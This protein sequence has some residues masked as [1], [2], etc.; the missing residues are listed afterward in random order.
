[1]KLLLFLLIMII[2]S[3][4]LVSAAQN[5]KDELRG[6]KREIKA[7]KQLITR[8]RKV[9][10][11]ISTEL[12]E[13]NRNLDQKVS[14]LGRLDH[15]LRGVESSLDRT[16][17][18]IGRVSEDAS[19]KRQ[20]IERRLTSLYKAGELGALRM[21]F[22]AESFPQIVENI[23][24]MRSI[25]DNDKR[26]FVEYNQKIE[27]LK[28]LKA[29][30]ER[31]A[32]KKER[33]LENMAQKKREIEQEKRKKADYLIKVRQD[34]KS[35]E[36]SL[37][38]LQTN[39]SRLQAMMVRLNALS[40][41]KL[42]SRH[43][44]PGSKPKPLADLP[45]VPDRGFASQKGRMTLPVRGAILESFGKHKHPEF[46]SYTFSKGLSISSSAGTEIKSIYEGNVIFADYF[47]GFGNMIIVDHGGGYFSLYAHASRIT[48]KV[49]AEVSRHE[50]I[51]TVGD[52]DSTKGTILYFEIR[53]QG[54]PVD[55]AGWVR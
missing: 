22:S 25:L 15:D 20:E 28:K 53:H 5:P 14:D 36:A 8:T 54:K 2:V 29:D 18:D 13:I 42:S 35:Y 39:A 48:K 43:E 31:D 38:E 11:V 45:A 34:R 30:L 17:H 41:R 27:E 26:I 3:A 6:V 33:I 12:Q 23:R 16:G 4:S 24:Y 50:T 49:G 7:Q 19:R 46:D 21:F 44:K 10:A 1:M 52:V 47:K 40:R 37:K 55:P 51:A 32:V 9:E